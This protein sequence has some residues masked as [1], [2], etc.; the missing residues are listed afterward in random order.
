L[1]I[2]FLELIEEKISIEKPPRM[3]MISFIEK[4]A[5]IFS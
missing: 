5:F 1:Y 3:W 2:D 4:L